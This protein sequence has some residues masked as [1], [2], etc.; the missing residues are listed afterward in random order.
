MT[1]VQTC[2]LPIYGFLFWFSR[3]HPAP[4]GCEADIHGGGTSRISGTIYGPTANV[5]MDGGGSGD[6]G[7]A[8]LQ[9]VVQN[10]EFKGGSTFTFQYDGREFAMLGLYG[11]IE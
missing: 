2:A 10:L 9:M 1:G 7:N 3:N 5:V 4:K 11:L 6:S 8:T